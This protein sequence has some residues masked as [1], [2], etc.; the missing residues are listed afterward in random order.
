MPDW[1]EVKD[2]LVAYLA[3]QI[4]L[5]AALAHGDGCA[6]NRRFILEWVPRAV[7]VEAVR[8]EALPRHLRSALLE[9]FAKVLLDVDGALNLREQIRS[10]RCL[11]SQPGSAAAYEAAHGPIERKRL[12]GLSRGDM[13][14][15]AAALQRY[16]REYF[17]VDHPTSREELQDELAPAVGIYAFFR[18][19]HD[20]HFLTAARSR[21]SSGDGGISTEDVARCSGLLWD[22]DVDHG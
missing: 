15:S 14:G 11:V 20:M 19:C 21:Y 17:H 4:R 6:S 12:N 9:L 10:I 8:S 22:V 1:P 16:F 13:A 2:T 5:L 3:A 18:A 7:L